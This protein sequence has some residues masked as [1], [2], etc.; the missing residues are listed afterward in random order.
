MNRTDPKVGRPIEILL[1]EDSPSDT[2]LTMEALGAGKV[3]NRLSIVEDGVK[4]MEFLRRQGRYADAPRPDLIL[5]DLNLPRKDGRE[6]LA[7][8]KADASLRHIPVVVL[9]T[10]QAE[11]DVLRA[12]SLHAN[13]YVTKPVD[14]RQFIEVIR[15]IEDFWLTIVKLPGEHAPGAKLPG[16][17]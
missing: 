17:P 16:P 8:V 2:D 3:S 5:L 6:V 9:T 12:Y 15:G 14:F 13:C 10:S 1:V 11:Q 7:E 4:A